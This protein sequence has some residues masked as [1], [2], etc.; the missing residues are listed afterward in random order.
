MPSFSK[1]LMGPGSTATRQF[2]TLT[3]ISTLLTVLKKLVKTSKSSHKVLPIRTRTFQRPSNRTKCQ[4]VAEEPGVVPRR[5]STTKCTNSSSLKCSAH[6][7]SKSSLLSKIVSLLKQSLKARLARRW[8]QPSKCSS[9]SSSLFMEESSLPWDGKLWETLLKRA[10]LNLLKKPTIWTSRSFTM[11]LKAK[12]KVG[13]K[14]HPLIRWWMCRFIP[15]SK[16]FRGSHTKFL[17]CKVATVRRCSTSKMYYLKSA[18]CR[19]PTQMQLRK[20]HTVAIS[21]LIKALLTAIWRNRRSSNQAA[22]IMWMQ[23]WCI[24]KCKVYRKLWQQALRAR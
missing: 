8:W 5:W 2:K 22:T 24:R 9:S 16:P 19:V 3:G 12:W 21:K 14:G 7:I 23:A 10:R 4:E 15:L 11:C 13:L 20:N 1:L 6:W 18:R 17:K